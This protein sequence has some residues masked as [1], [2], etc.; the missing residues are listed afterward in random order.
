MSLHDFLFHSFFT[1]YATC[2]HTTVYLPHVYV[3][4]FLS[5]ANLAF[6]WS[7]VTCRGLY[8]VD[9]MLVIR[10]S[11]CR[12]RH[13][14]HLKTSLSS[15]G[16][17][18]HSR[19]PW[20]SLIPTVLPASRS[21]ASWIDKETSL[22]PAKIRRSQVQLVE[23]LSSTNYSR[24]LFDWLNGV[25]A[26][27][28][29]LHLPKL[30]LLYLWNMEFTGRVSYFIVQPIA[31][32]HWMEVTCRRVHISITRLQLSF[33]TILILINLRQYFFSNIKAIFSH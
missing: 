9:T 14:I 32:K 25:T 24:V 17:G 4:F 30:N 31:S 10:S 8:Q 3:V 29:V 28:A 19:R 7:N 21:I 5:S 12:R 23:W 11:R 15:Q 2:T 6:V 13:R 33:V 16:R 18:R 20:N 1:G 27:W 22:T 26:R